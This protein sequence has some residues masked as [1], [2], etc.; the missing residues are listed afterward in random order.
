MHAAPNII[1]TKSSTLATKSVIARFGDN[2]P[3]GC[4]GSKEVF[5]DIEVL[6]TKLH[7]RDRRYVD[8]AVLPRAPSRRLTYRSL[9]AR[10]LG[11]SVRM[12]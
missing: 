5:W 12:L 8:G 1:S 9:L 11:Q 10:A 3:S 2:S 4:K 7:D 6:N